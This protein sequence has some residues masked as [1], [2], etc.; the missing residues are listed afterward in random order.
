MAAP[1]ALL[2]ASALVAWLLDEK[3]ADTIERIIPVAA[4][5][6]VNLVES[7]ER[8]AVTEWSLGE[9]VADL[10][11]Y[12]LDILPVEV[13]DAMQIPAIRAA[14][15]AVPGRAGRSV[16]SLGDCCCLA[17]A[18]LRGIPVVTDDSAWL[19]LEIGVKVHLFR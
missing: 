14:G 10:R 2:D 6:A 12:G 3:G 17:A 5:T 16:L 19:G 1:R 8:A 4:I 15:R 7:L 11:A 9:T 18:K 13:E